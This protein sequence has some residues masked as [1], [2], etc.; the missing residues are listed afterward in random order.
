MSASNGSP[1]HICMLC[2]ITHVK[3]NIHLSVRTKNKSK[4]VKERKKRWKRI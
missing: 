3:T 1:F 2:Y 4:D